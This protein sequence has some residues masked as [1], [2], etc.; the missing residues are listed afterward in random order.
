MANLRKIAPF[1]DYISII[2]LSPE[3]MVKIEGNLVNQK[4]DIIRSGLDEV[5][6]GLFRTSVIAK[7]GDE[8]N[9]VPDRSR[10][11]T[12]EY[13]AEVTNLKT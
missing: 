7:C 2:D 6:A 4:L 8:K 3:Q 12:N 5:F 9:E 13:L 1:F 10:Q 11:R